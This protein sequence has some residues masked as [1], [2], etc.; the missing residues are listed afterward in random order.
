[1]GARCACARVWAGR[2]KTAAVLSVRQGRPMSGN[3]AYADTPPRARA[4]QE[5]S[6]ESI[7]LKRPGMAL[8]ILT[9][10]AFDASVAERLCAIR[11]RLAIETISAAV[12][13]AAPDPNTYSKVRSVACQHRPPRSCVF[14][15]ICSGS[16]ESGFS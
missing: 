16:C 12:N 3:T 11:D 9:S 5:A 10:G 14:G 6:V 13:I 1:M 15:L 2:S 7:L 8:G 4:N